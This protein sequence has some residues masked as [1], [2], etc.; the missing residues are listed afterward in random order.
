MTYV[1]QIDL[2]GGPKGRFQTQLC[3][4]SHSLKKKLLLP[5]LHTVAIVICNAWF[6]HLCT[7]TNSTANLFGRHG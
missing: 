1:G 5:D 3:E 7:M 6:L 2:N 4:D